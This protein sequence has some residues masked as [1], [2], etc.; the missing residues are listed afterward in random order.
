MICHVSAKVWRETWKSGGLAV[1]IGFN[2]RDAAADA[3]LQPAAAEL[4]EHA[5]FFG[6]PQRM[7]KGQDVDQRTKPQRPGAL[8]YRAKKDA[9][10]R[11]HAE[12][13]EM[14]LGDVVAVKAEAFVGLR[15]LDA[16]FEELPQR[17]ARTIDMIEDT[18]F[19]FRLPAAYFCS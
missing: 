3:E 9:R 10:R 12:R 17:H 4:V 7:I 8:R 6:K 15:N 19:H 18:K 14:M 2:G 5:D 13:R 16:L 1:V 11:R